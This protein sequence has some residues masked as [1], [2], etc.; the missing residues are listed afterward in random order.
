MNKA[1]KTPLN[2]QEFSSLDI[3]Q[4][5]Q[6]IPHRYPFLLV[7]RI[8]EV[9]KEKGVGIKNYSATEPFFQGHFPGRPV[10]PGV[11]ILES[12]AQVAGIVALRKHGLRRA[13]L[14]FLAGIDNARFREPVIPG[15]QLTIESRCIKEKGRMYVAEG[16]ARV[17]DKLV[18]EATILFVLQ[19]F[20]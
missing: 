9:D 5:E 3:R 10:V 17:H 8:L 6:V 20:E 1:Q 7:D 11:L 12:M 13:G 16:T 2:P 4:I 19:E 18:C 15:D 14:A